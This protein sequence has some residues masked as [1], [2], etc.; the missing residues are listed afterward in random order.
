[1]TRTLCGLFRMITIAVDCMG[2]DHGPKVDAAC[3]QPVSGSAIQMLALVLVGLAGCIRRVFASA[4]HHRCR[5]AKWSPWTTRWKSPCAR[6]KTRLCAWP[7]QQVKDGHAQ[8]AVSAGNTGALDG[9][10]PLRAEDAGRHRAPGHSGPHCPTPRAAP[11]PCWTSGANVDCQRRALASVCGD[12]LGAG[13]G[14]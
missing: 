9:H 12:G 8:A 2:G 10:L 6:R 3:L 13:I 7:V 1:M 14:A 11:P 5:Q 4:R